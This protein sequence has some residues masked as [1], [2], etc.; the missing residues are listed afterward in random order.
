MEGAVDITESTFRSN[1][2]SYS[3][4]AHFNGRL[5]VD[6]SCFEDNETGN[7]GVVFVGRGRLCGLRR[8]VFVGRGAF[9]GDISNNYGFGNDAVIVSSFRTPCNGGILI[10]DEDELCFVTDTCQDECIPFDA[11]TCQFEVMDSCNEPQAALEQCLSS[12]LLSDPSGP[13][14]EWMNLDPGVGYDLFFDGT[15]CIDANRM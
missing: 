13:C 8:G 1:T 7:E 6:G 11:E 3:V 14:L 10:E 9:E 15:D 5:S 4:V 12:A 2:V